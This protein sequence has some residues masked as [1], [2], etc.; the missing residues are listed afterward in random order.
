MKFF[1]R[2]IGGQLAAKDNRTPNEDRM[3][4]LLHNGGSC[5]NAEN[6]TAILAWYAAQ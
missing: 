3:L 2:A 6:L 5:V 1:I 4:N